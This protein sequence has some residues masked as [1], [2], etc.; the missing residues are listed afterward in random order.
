MQKKDDLVRGLGFLALIA[1]CFNCTVGGGIFRLP[2]SV[3]A[4]AGRG[5]LFVYVL[6]FLVMLSVAQVFIQVGRTITVSG[7]PYAYV[8]PILGSYWGYL[9]GVLLW[10]LATFAFASVG[11]AY[12]HF[13]ALLFTDGTERGVEALILGVS[14]LGLG[15]FNGRGVKSGARVSLILGGLKILP[16]LFLCAIGIPHL[17]F[18]H[19]FF[20]QSLNGSELA[21]GAMVLIFAFTGVECALIPSGEI[22]APE[23]TLPRALILSLTLVLF[24]Y[25]GVHSVSQSELGDGLSA[26]GI[27]PL[28]LAAEHLVGPVGAFILAVGAVISTLG[29]LSAMTL[30]LPRSLYAFSKDG[31]LP[32]F[33]SVVDSGSQAPVRAIWVQLGVVVFL[34]VSS[35]FE[36]LAG[37]WNLSAILMYGLCSI[38]ALIL[39]RRNSG[40]TL[41]VLIPISAMATMGFLLTSVTLLEWGSVIV[42]IALASFLYRFK[43]VKA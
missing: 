32:E 9:C 5:S 29:Y 31:Y 12:A 21:R 15:A 43:K 19:L 24:L 38:A 6:C 1:S 37:L 17:N 42:L 33:L 10:F 27:S 14:L 40:L 39:L 36:R 11:N 20:P 23:K 13:V 7:G 30:S 16:L 22:H 8:K 41:K 25:L 28:A 34:S 4:I 35:Q 2:Q 18:D 3:Y 26:P